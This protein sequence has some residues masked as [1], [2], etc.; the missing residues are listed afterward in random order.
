M[1][2]RHPSSATWMMWSSLVIEKKRPSLIHL[3][4]SQRAGLGSIHRLKLTNL[5]SHSLVDVLSVVGELIHQ[6]RHGDHLNVTFIA[7]KNIMC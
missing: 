4:T 1:R 7:L 6:T 2:K 5:R 3:T